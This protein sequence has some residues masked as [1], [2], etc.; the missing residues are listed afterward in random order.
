MFYYRVPIVLD[1]DNNEL[2]FIKDV[3]S[4]SDR[5]LVCFDCGERMLPVHKEGNIQKP[6]FRHKIKDCNASYESYIH[7]LSKKV[8]E[9]FNSIKLPSIDFR[10][11]YENYWINDDEFKGVLN[12]VFEDLNLS[13]NFRNL[14]GYNIILRESNYLCFDDFEKETTSKTNMG[15]IRTDLVLNAGKE[16]YFI[17]PFYTHN[18]EDKALSVIESLN[19]ST[20]SINLNVFLEEMSF[21][22]SKEQFIDFI[23]N[24]TLSKKWVYINAKERERLFLCFVEQL[25]DLITGRGSL[26]EEYRKIW[27][28]KELILESKKPLFKELRKLRENRYSIID[29]IN[30]LNKNISEI[31]DENDRVL[32]EIDLIDKEYDKVETILG[33]IEKGFLSNTTI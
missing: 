15:V 7:W 21:V 26:I 20:I 10:F 31:M 18:I 27:N 1:I 4:G 13:K 3:N 5:N 6:H 14:S 24:D 2:V 9:E 17:E 16:K 29:Q 25:K 8:F 33:E 11:I 30:E 32:L 19:Y 12:G 23:K 22:Y 28:S